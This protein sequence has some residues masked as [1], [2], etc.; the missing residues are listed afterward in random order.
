VRKEARLPVKIAVTALLA[1]A[2]GWLWIYNTFVQWQEY[3]Y[4]VYLKGD[5]VP[6]FRIKYHRWPETLGG[7]EQDLQDRTDP[8]RYAAR[9]DDRLLATHRA[10]RPALAI[11][12]LDAKTLRGRVKFSWFF[13]HSYDLVVRN[14]CL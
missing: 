11:L 2:V 1:A 3:K 5:Y 4:V 7:V 12:Y 8:A 10:S 14:R 6:R 9:I 13:G